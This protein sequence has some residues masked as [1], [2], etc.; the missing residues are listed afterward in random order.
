MSGGCCRQKLLNDDD[1]LLLPDLA[2]TQKSK[3]VER[4]RNGMFPVYVRSPESS[5]AA[6]RVT[7]AKSKVG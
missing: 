4:V 6:E 3:A 1:W 5:G 2:H 7:G